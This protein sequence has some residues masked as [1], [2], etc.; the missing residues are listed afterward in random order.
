M[1][2]LEKALVKLLKTQSWNKDE[3]EDIAEFLAPLINRAFRECSYE[4]AQS[5]LSMD[6]AEEQGLESLR[7]SLNDV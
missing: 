7:E 6:N 2:E 4:Y 3:R 1:S 5:H